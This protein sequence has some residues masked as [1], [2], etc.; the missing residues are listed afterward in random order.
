LEGM[1]W[2]GGFVIFE[3]LICKR[4]SKPSGT[5]KRLCP[6]GWSKFGIILRGG[7]CNVRRLF[8]SSQRKAI[9]RVCL[10]VKPCR[11]ILM[12][13]TSRISVSNTKQPDLA[14]CLL[15]AQVLEP[16]V[17]AL[18]L[19]RKFR[20]AHCSFESGHRCLL[21]FRKHIVNTRLHSDKLFSYSC[22]RMFWKYLLLC[23]PL[24]LLKMVIEPS[25][26]STA[27]V[28]VLRCRGYANYQQTV[29]GCLP[30]LSNGKPLLWQ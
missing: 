25:K 9:N 7:T 23:W 12:T 4:S 28:W 6:L 27:E 17:L 2:K 3:I 14:M 10:K 5:W 30:N 15:C 21:Y 22:T 26:S 20:S 13:K 1:K 8:P 29:Y 18:C 11:F 19:L 16:I 24:P